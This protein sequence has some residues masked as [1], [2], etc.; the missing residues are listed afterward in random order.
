MLKSCR[1]VSSLWTEAWCPVSKTRVS[2]GESKTRCNAMVSSTTPRFGPRWPPVLETSVTRKVRISSARSGSW[3]AGSALSA[4]GLVIVSSRATLPRPLGSSSVRVTRRPAT[5]VGRSS[6]RVNVRR[7]P[8]V[9]RGPHT[10]LTSASQPRREHLPLEGLVQQ[11]GRSRGGEQPD[12]LGLDLAED[13]RECLGRHVRPDRHPRLTPG[14][15][16]GDD[17]AVEVPAGQPGERD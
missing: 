3:V 9:A 7:L 12:A 11:S 6:L 17:L 10:V 15:P 1:P 2:C 16:H 5:R 4:V 14:V 8:K 13:L